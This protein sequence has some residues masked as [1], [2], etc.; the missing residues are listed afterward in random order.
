MTGPWD[1]LLQTGADALLE[2]LRARIRSK[3]ADQAHE[4]ALEDAA[5]KA[6]LQERSAQA[7]FAR[8]WQAE[9]HAAAVQLWEQVTLHAE[10]MRQEAS[11]FK[12]PGDDIRSIAGAATRKGEFPALIFAPFLDRLGGSAGIDVCRQLW[13]RAQQRA[14]WTEGLVGLSGH[15]RPVSE[16][17]IDMALIRNM[18]GDLPFVLIHGDVEVDRVQ[19]RIVGSGVLPQ[20]G[21]SS[22]SHEVSATGPAVSIC[23]TLP[24]PDVPGGYRLA[25]DMIDAV[26]ASAGALG[27][28][29]HLARSRR[30]PELHKRVP[31]WLRPGVTAMIIGG[32]GVAVEKTPWDADI[33]RGLQD[34]VASMPGHDDL[35]LR[36]RAEELLEDA[37]E[38]VAKRALLES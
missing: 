20:P 28:V 12:L 23:G 33:V 22:P 4:H 9:E 21:V 11:P 6:E 14:D 37:M 2:Q 13:W 7:D 29:F 27:E 3:E 34:L 25:E 19:V 17:D 18:L 16:L 10:R 36:R 31:D 30:L 8:A 15:M 32:Y 5:V 38:S 26:L 24:W 35:G 1:I